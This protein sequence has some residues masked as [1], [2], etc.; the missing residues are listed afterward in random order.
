MKIKSLVVA[1]ALLVLVQVSTTVAFAADMFSGTWK[2]NL[3]KS[4]YKPGPPPKEPTI[5]RYEAT[6]DGGMKLMSDGITAGG[7]PAHSEYTFQFDGK[8]YPGIQTLDGKPNEN[9]AEQT[10]SAKKI[11]DYTIEFT[12]KKRGMVTA[13]AKAVISKDGKTETYTTTSTTREGEDMINVTIWEKQ[14]K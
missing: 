13:T 5:S 2:L 11:D 12:F 3:A 9:S 6:K 4:T 14:L 8:D 10:I 7:K 1:F